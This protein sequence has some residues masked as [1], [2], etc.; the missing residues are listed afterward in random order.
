MIHPDPVKAVRLRRRPRPGRRVDDRAIDD[1]L[2]LV[3]PHTDFQG[4][5]GL[6]TGVG[7]L[8]GIARRFLG[9]LPRL[10]PVP[11]FDEP[12]AVLRDHEVEIIL[13]R[14]FEIASTED[15][16]VV[17]HVAAR[18]HQRECSFE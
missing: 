13:R 14:A 10:L 7:L 18:L 9:D 11:P 8:H 12:R 17:V 3:G 4:V 5:S 1:V 6:S 15:E 16:T 2:D